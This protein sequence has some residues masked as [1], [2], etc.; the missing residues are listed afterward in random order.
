MFLLVSCYCG[1]NTKTGVDDS[2]EMSHLKKMVIEYV[3]VENA[4]MGYSGEMYCLAW[5]NISRNFAKK[6]SRT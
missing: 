1:Q 6:Q 3:K 2:W 5:E 4:V